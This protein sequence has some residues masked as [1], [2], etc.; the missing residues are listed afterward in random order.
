MVPRPICCLILLSLSVAVAFGTDRPSDIAPP[1]PPLAI[2]PSSTDAPRPLPHVASHSP[3]E[4]LRR[5]ADHLEAAAIEDLEDEMKNRAREL[6][7]TADKIEQE[8]DDRLTKLREELHTIQ[9]EIR[10]LEQFTNTSS[11]ILV[12]LRIIEIDMTA[13]SEQGMQPDFLPQGHFQLKEN[14]HPVR[15]ASA[16]QNHHVGFAASDPGEMTMKVRKMVEA[17]IAK[18]LA[19]PKLITVSGRPA[20]LHSGGEFPILVP[21]TQGTVSIEWREFGVRAEVV[22][23]ILDNGRLRLDVAPEI[24]ERNFSNSVNVE[25]MVIPGITT[26]RINTQVE[27]D[28]GQ[29][30]VIGGLVSTT[31]EPH[32]T[33]G[34]PVPGRDRHF[35]AVKRPGK[36]R[37]KQLIVLVTPSRVMSS[38]D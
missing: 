12:D 2:P 10:K 19:E 29:T 26:R 35:R 23:V 9:Q 33:E 17:G 14:G 8:V 28:F 5:A 13:A 22:P 36:E 24:S 1:A 30:L 20:S 16:E 4:H 25:G 6:R 11:Q 7:E 3:V 32:V 31:T 38:S 34:V 21:Q 37:E 15:L 27:M 18:V